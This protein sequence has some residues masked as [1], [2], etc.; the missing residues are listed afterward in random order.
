[1]QNRISISPGIARYFLG[2]V[3]AIVF[4]LIARPASAQVPVGCFQCIGWEIQNVPTNNGLCCLHPPYGQCN[5]TVC[6]GDTIQFYTSNQI[7]NLTWVCPGSSGL[8]S[9]IDTASDYTLAYFNN[10]GSYT[11][12]VTVAD[13]AVS[14]GCYGS[15]LSIGINVVDVPQI[16]YS[17]STNTPCVGDT[18]CFTTSITGT[19]DPYATSPLTPTIVIDYGDGVGG[20]ANY[21]TN[22]IYSGNDCY[23]YTDTGT[24]FVTIMMV[25][26]DTV[27]FKDTIYVGPPVPSFTV[28]PGCGMHF[29]DSTSCQNGISDWFWDFGN[30][31]TLA[32]TSHLQNPSYFY[33][34]HNKTY[35]VTLTITDT[36]GH[37]YSVQQAITTPPLPDATITGAAANNC[38]NGVMTYTAPCDSNVVYTWYVDNGTGTQTDKCEIEVDWSTSGGYIVLYA[39]DTITD[40]SNFDTLFIPECCSGGVNLNNRTASSVLTD[41]AFVGYVTGTEF[42][43]T[44]QLAINGVFTVD[45]TFTF[46]LCT[47]ILMGGN[48]QI[49]VLPTQKLTFDS[50]SFD[51]KCQIMWDGIYVNGVTAQLDVNESRVRYAKNAVVSV[52]GGPYQIDN[53]IFDACVRD[54]VVLPYAGTHNSNIQGTTFQM[55]ESFLTCVPPLAWGVDRT[56]W[57]VEITGNADIMIGDTAAGMNTFDS[58]FGGV[59]SVNSNA[60]V[61]NN[62]FNGMLRSIPVSAQSTGYGVLSE[63]AK[64]LTYTPKITVGGVGANETNTLINVWKGIEARGNQDVDIQKNTVEKVQT[65]GFGIHAT[66]QTL[67]NVIVSYNTVNNQ[68]SGASLFGEGILVAECYDANVTMRDNRVFQYNGS[69]VQGGVGI[70]VALAQPGTV[71]LNMFDNRTIRSVRTG[72]WLQNIDGQNVAH[73]S[74][75]R[76][77]F[78]SGKSYYQ[79]TGPLHFGIRL[80]NCVGIHVDENLIERGISGPPS[81]NIWTLADSAKIRRLRGISFENSPLSM[82]SENELRDMGEGVYGYAVSSASSLPCNVFNRCY[83]GFNFGGPALMLFRADIGDQILHPSNMSTPAPT[84]N[85]W[86]STVNFDLEG[87][88]VLPGIHWYHDNVNVPLPS[89][90][91]GSFAAPAFAPEYSSNATLC[92]SAYFL[93]PLPNDTV[94]RDLEVGRVIRALWMDTTASDERIYYTLKYAHRKLEQNPSWL[95]LGLADDTLYQQVWDTTEPY[96]HGRFREAEEFAALSERDSFII[97]N[98]AV[99]SALAYE[100]NAQDVNAIYADSWMMGQLDFAPVDSATLYSIAMQEPVAG[101]PGVYY[102][103]AMLGLSVDDLTGVDNSRK[104]RPEPQTVTT[105]DVFK[106]FPNPANDL[107]TVQYTLGENETGALEIF[108]L[109]GRLIVTRTLAAADNRAEVS[110][111]GLQAGTYVVRLLVSG[112]VR[113]AARLVIIK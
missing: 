7:Y 87:G 31:A 51:K 108:D 102:A 18:V 49:Q 66:G 17:V 48:A 45:T 70:R 39:V 32:D 64:N 103:R 41:P 24:Y 34:L 73:V 86:N 21:G 25:G 36:A 13:S 14:A 38:G 83:N 72:I 20:V 54:V 110:V 2:F 63:G 59:H 30:P 5:I 71:Y 1:M 8:P 67:R 55:K 4:L 61:Q 80:E 37:T 40:C 91:G 3:V 43:Y 97:A 15:S 46:N 68:F 35:T 81:T 69:S 88:I 26:C 23:V 33:P 75:N 12:T 95:S 90:L 9:G 113:E 60:V 76:V 62:R 74:R 79:A 52:S 92:D 100:T 58:L 57:A 105:P 104:G 10:P 82:V 112:E 101:G 42:K 96:N 11:L 22:P 85:D 19:N 29:F 106:L 6:K 28:V 107:V 16:T 99:S 50:C 27:Y 47:Q 44:N 84:G 65:G 98:S 53:S 93:A 89:M 109:S 94:A 111:T 78:Q 77:S 56:I